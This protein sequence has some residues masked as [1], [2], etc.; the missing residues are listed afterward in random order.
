MVDYDYKMEDLIDEEERERNKISS[1]IASIDKCKA[2]LW[3]KK[4]F[5]DEN[6]VTVI[7]YN[8][9]EYFNWNYEKARR[10]L[11]DFHMQLKIIR[12]Y[13]YGKQKEKYKSSVVQYVLIDKKLLDKI[14]LEVIKHRPEVINSKN[15]AEN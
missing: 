7:P 3:L 5:E 6:V 2:I 12:P 9:V 14:V 11:K 4:Y 8:L 15:E 1:V 13:I 10:I